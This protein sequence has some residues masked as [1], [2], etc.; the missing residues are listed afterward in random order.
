MLLRR[1]IALTLVLLGVVGACARVSAAAT[2]S[3][4]DRAVYQSAFIAV[5]DDKWPVAQALAAKAKDPLLA[6]VILWLNLMSPQSGHDFSDYADTGPAL[7]AYLGMMEHA[8]PSLPRFHH[9]VGVEA[10]LSEELD[11]NP[12]LDPS[13]REG[14]HRRAEAILARAEWVRMV[15]GVLEST[16]AREVAGVVGVAERLGVETRPVLWDWLSRAPRDGF[17]WYR[18]T[19][20]ADRDDM[21]RLVEEA[22]ALLPLADL[23]TGPGDDLGLGREYEADNCLGYVLQGLREFPGKGWSVISTTRSGSFVAS[24]MSRSP[25]SSRYSGR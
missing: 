21:A 16:D 5:E 15:H 17:F 22:S 8:T 9:L 11:G 25:R 20:G 1:W 10:Y 6:K 4:S 24:R 3:A 7:S 19:V 2:L 14:L 18:L 13:A 12:H 23:A